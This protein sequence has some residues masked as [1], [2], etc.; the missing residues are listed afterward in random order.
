MRLSTPL[1][2]LLMTGCAAIGPRF[3]PEVAASFARDKMHRL[4]TRSLVVYY[5]AQSRDAALAIAARIEACAQILKTEVKSR[6]ERGKPVILVTRAEFNNAFVHAR[7]AGTPPEM[8][9]PVQL[10]LELF[11]F[12]DIGVVNVPDVACHEAV[13]Y[14]QLEQTDGFWRI[15][16][17]V[18]GDLVSPNLATETWFLEGL[19]TWS[20]S[21]FGWRSGRPESPLWGAMFE[22]GIASQGGVLQPGQLSPAHRELYPFGGHYLAGSEFVGW[23]AEKYGQDKLWEL[24]DRQGHAVFFPF[25]V[26]LRFQAVYG[27]TI[28]A[29]LDEFNG[30]LRRTV[31]RRQRPPSQRVRVE[32]AGYFARLASAPDGTLALVSIGGD[33]PSRLDVFEPDGRLRFS[34]PLTPILPVRAW[35]ASHPLSISGLSFTADGRFLFF[36]TEDVGVDTESTYAVRQFDALTG[37]H[38]RSW[39]GLRGLGGQ[40]SPDGKS[41]VFVAIEN[42]VANL[43]RLDLS[44]GRVEPLTAFTSPAS[45]GGVAISP[46]GRRIAFSRRSSSGFDLLLREEDGSLSP[47]THDGQFNYDARWASVD[48]LVFMR[49]HDERAQAYSL[50]LPSGALRRITDVPYALLDPAPLPGGRVAFLNREGWRWTVDEAP[51]RPAMVVAAE[52]PQATEDGRSSGDAGTSDE[53]QAPATADPP[54][55]DP[56]SQQ[57]EVLKDERYSGLD[58]LFIPRVRGLLAMPLVITDAG[59]RRWFG[60]AGMVGFDR[61]GLHTWSLDASYDSFVGVPSVA[62][63]YGNSQLAPWFVSAN[64]TRLADRAVLFDASGAPVDARVTEFQGGLSAAR[65]F[66]TTS[67]SLGV[68]GLWHRE[69]DMT[70][71]KTVERVLR[72]VGPTLALSWFAGESTAYAGTRRGLSFD[73]AGTVYPRGPSSVDLADLRGRVG[74]WLP[75]PLLPRAT[76]ALSFRGRALT[77]P[78][79]GLLQIGGVSDAVWM[80][81]EPRSSAPQAQLPG[82]AFAEA[83]RGFD[84]VAFRVNA[85]AIAGA[86]FRQPVIIDGGTTSFLWLL[87]SFFVRQL[88]A[89][90]FFEGAR[91]DVSVAFSPIGE[92]RRMHGAVGG[93]A[94]LRTLGG[95]TLPLSVYYQYAY[96][97]EPTLGALHTV[98]IEFE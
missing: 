96:R 42:A 78:V 74:V 10:G 33:S 71:Q 19:A 98:G 90:A 6:T 40:V 21:H 76:L 58:E 92:P 62:A 68:T 95:S 13:H 29:L 64:L 59:V 38:V 34:R 49:A 88:E 31:E 2:L 52:S 54:R 30:S 5:P 79:G 82:V 47:L 41:Y 55:S 63:A 7:L 50:F 35:I 70:P 97:L 67:L 18:F 27:K 23:L 57:L 80:S 39:S 53:S 9:V 8:I 81:S 73:V 22:S 14:F 91:T 65:P 86:R 85:V 72:L 56:P 11:N 4:E 84:D 43:A 17:L 16:N 1:A 77:S 15:A 37:D 93:L 45:M 32:D 46:D 83:L 24:V 36:L 12:F 94:R 75:V 89:E 44:T 48:E 66:W 61:L 60:A 87:P 69:R 28:G 26:T 25:G 3:S 20:E 51:L